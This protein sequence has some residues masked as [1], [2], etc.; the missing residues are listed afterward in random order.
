MTNKYADLLA[1]LNNKPRYYN[2]N[3]L[4]IDGLNMFL[5]SFTMIN[6]INQLGAHIGGLTGFLKSLGYVIK[7]I[8]P[9]QVIVLFDGV[10]GSS[11]RKN[12]YPGYKANRGYGRM[13]NYDI[14][15]SKEE[16]NESIMNQMERLIQYL[17]C[18]PIKMLS[19]DGL[20]ADDIIGY[21]SQHFNKNNE[22]D[23]IS[24]VSADK[25]F[26]Q[27][28]NNKIEVFSP[29]KKKFYDEG[30]ILEEYSISSSNFII[31]KVLLGDKSDNIPGVIGLGPKKLLKYFP[32][33][34][35]ESEFTLDEVFEKSLNNDDVM[36]K[37]VLEVK[38][39]LNINH[40]L[41]SLKDIPI[42]IDNL[43]IIDNCLQSL[44]NTFSN[45][46]FLSLYYRDQLGDSIPYVE[47][48]LSEVFSH[49][50]SFNKL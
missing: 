3:I 20:E 49:L 46:N 40:Q 43:E 25:D 1:S 26:L 50:N 9:T 13:T 30:K 21:M 33:L 15:S 27:L 37:K 39:Q 38:N 8:N 36:Y 4:L 19:I 10:G 45:Y 5:R 47:K 41:M 35:N 2:S 34:Q 22:T 14:F 18:L 42:S 6:H 44:P 11:S 17:Q 12:L 24:I 28:V 23:K 29:I 7:M 48:W 32:E 31:Y 16:E